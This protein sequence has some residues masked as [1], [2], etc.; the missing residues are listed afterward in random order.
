MA[1][2]HAWHF[3]S[4]PLVQREEPELRT[5][6]LALLWPVSCSLH[7]PLAP[8]RP[9]SLPTGCRALDAPLVSGGEVGAF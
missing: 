4:M 6:S 7:L 5:S 9:V 8:A 2:R 3:P 1:S